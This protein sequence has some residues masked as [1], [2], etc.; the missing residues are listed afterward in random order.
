MLSIKNIFLKKKILIYGLGKSGMSS[1]NFLKKKSNL[2]IFDDRLNKKIYKKK[3]IN[4]NFDFIILSPGIDINKCYLK[5]FIK[6]NQ[7]KIVTDFDIFYSF[8]KNKTITITGT[9]GKSTT[10]KILHKVLLDQNYDARLV[11]NIGNPILSEKKI[12][13]KTI[14]IIEASSYQLEYS[15]VFKTN[16]SILLNISPDHIERHRTMKNYINA[17]LKL[18]KNQ[19]RNSLSL[20]N[21]KDPI[22]K[23][24]INC[25]QFLSKIIK[26]NPLVKNT[27]LNKI[28]NEYFESDG[29]KQNLSFIIKISQIFKLNK[30]KLLKSLKNF[31]GLDYRQQI[32][33]RLKNLTIINDSKSTS[34]SSSASLLKSL[35]DVYWILGGIPKKNDKFILT[36]NSCK[37]FK[38]F[39]FG[40]NVN[41][42]YNDLKHKM[43]CK[44]FKNLKSAIYYIFSDLKKKENNKKK[45]ILLFSPSAASFD[46]FKNF[47]HRGEYF[48]KIIRKYLYGLY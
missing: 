21:I 5:S 41:K 11:G 47:E 25:N 40:N 44:K 42:F 31:K 35:D 29:N 32:I 17:K 12:T 2:V 38:A 34:Y 36:K 19:T 3:I 48:N 10:S 28:K 45:K 1:F 37:N 15:K 39:I 8:Y 6:R 43:K 24:E 46:D 7:H 18:I 14:F 33:Y 22:I 16:F 27:L 9:N 4:N 13:K 20:I 23:K 26:V 30:K